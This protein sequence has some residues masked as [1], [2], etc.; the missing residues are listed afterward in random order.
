MVWKRKGSYRM[1][2]KTKSWPTEANKNFAFD[3]NEVRI[4]LKRTVEGSTYL[5]KKSIQMLTVLWAL[6]QKLL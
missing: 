6:N 4:S 1:C 5:K 3:F 2:A